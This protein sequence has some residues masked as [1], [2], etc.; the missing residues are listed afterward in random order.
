[1]NIFVKSQI[2]KI[3]NLNQCDMKDIGA[4][5]TLAS[6]MGMKA[7]VTFLYTSPKEYLSYIQKFEEK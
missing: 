1:M 3:H 2:N 4:V 7:L 5:S 6:K